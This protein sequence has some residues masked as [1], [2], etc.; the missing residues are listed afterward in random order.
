[1]IDVVNLLDDDGQVAHEG[2][3]VIV[4]Q[5]VHVDPMLAAGDEGLAVAATAKVGR[6]RP[7]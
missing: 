1:M 5:D 6:V 4:V 3:R 7:Y 2:G